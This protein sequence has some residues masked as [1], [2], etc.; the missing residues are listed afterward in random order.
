MNAYTEQS[1]Y[2][3]AGDRVSFDA[4][5][6]TQVI[7]ERH[8]HLARSTSYPAF[9]PI[10]ARRI[11]ALVRLYEDACRECSIDPNVAIAQLCHETGYLTSWW[12]LRN[13]N[14]AGIGVTG[15][16]STTMPRSL[17]RVITFGA[18][19][20]TITAATWAYD[21]EARVWRK[22]LTFLTWE[23]AVVA[24]IGRLTAY[25]LRKDERTPIQEAYVSLALRF[26]DLPVSAHGS[27]KT[28]AALGKAK[29][30]SGYGWASP[31]ER[32]GE[33]IA[34]IARSFRP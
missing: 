5:H 34:D 23:D 31:G 26:R 12:F 15:E 16:T 25:A 14:P 30:P 1:S 24:H 21:D 6:T 28:L 19:L 22:G 9:Y 7:N 27:A 20:I 18:A 2:I 11:E 4:A 8:R 29:N 10:H 3:V 17:T 32:Y 13:N 33:R